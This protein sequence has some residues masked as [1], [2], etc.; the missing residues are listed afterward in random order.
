VGM[1]RGYESGA[2]SRRCAQCL[3][4]PA[5]AETG[6]C[7]F[8]QLLGGSFV[9]RVEDCAHGLGS[10]DRVDELSCV[11]VSRFEHA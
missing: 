9:V 11:G 10:A 3:F 1:L 6:P 5:D 7:A 4:D 8:A 2:E